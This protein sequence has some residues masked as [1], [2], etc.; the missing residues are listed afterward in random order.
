MQTAIIPI[1]TCEAIDKRIRDFVWGSTD[2]ASKVHLVAW[3]RICLPKE[4]GGLGLKSA[5]FLNRAYMMKLAFTLFQE[6]DKLWVKILQSK[7]LRE[8]P[9]GFELRSLS[10]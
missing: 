8:V 2:E 1:A 5:R 6:P 7:Y 10:S 4:A 9:N 3:D